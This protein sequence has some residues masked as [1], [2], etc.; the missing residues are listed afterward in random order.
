MGFQNRFCHG[1]RS[2]YTK[3]GAPL[4]V[5][6]FK[7]FKE[8]SPILLYLVPF[9]RVRVGHSV[10]AIPLASAAVVYIWL[11]STVSCVVVVVREVLQNPPLLRNELLRGWG[12]KGRVAIPTPVGICLQYQKR[13]GRT[14]LYHACPSGGRR[15][16]RRGRRILN[17]GIF[18]RCRER[19]AV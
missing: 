18:I 5:P 16:K 15:G 11:S 8:I 2:I 19:R 17:G 3:I 9:R 14:V 4:N 12:R 1:R 7:L 10:H 13:P 6:I